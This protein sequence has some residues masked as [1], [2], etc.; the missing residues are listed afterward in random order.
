MVHGIK[1]RW[2]GQAC[3]FSGRNLNTQINRAKTAEREIIS[4]L[5]LRDS[6][7][8]HGGARIAS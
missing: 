5:L 2:W 1:T 7:R 4:K 6:D 3:D 8:K